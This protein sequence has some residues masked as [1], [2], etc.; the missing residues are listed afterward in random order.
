M[1]WKRSDLKPGTVLI[2]ESVAVLIVLA[3]FIFSTVAT[4]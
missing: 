1:K 4:A 3:V 2:I